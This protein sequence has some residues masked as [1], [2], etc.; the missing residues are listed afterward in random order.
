MKIGIVCPYNMFQ[1]AGGVQDVVV[2]LHRELKRKGHEVRVITPKPRNF[3]HEVP[4][5]YILLGRSAKVHTMATMVDIGFEAVSSEID[6][7]LE[8]E[9]FDVIHFHEP[10]IPL[11]SRQ[12]LTRSSAVN[13]GTF[14][15][16]SPETIMSKSFISSVGPYTKSILNYLDSLTAVSSAAS[17]YVVGMTDRLIEIV[18]NGID[19]TKFK[20]T[21][22]T[23]DQKNILYLGRLEKRKGIEYLIDAYR[24]VQNKHPE[25]ILKI[26][27]SGV[28]RKSLEKYVQQNSIS[29]VEFLGYVAEEDKPLLMED[30][31]VYCSPAPYGESFGI[32]LLEA[33]AVGTPVVAGNNVGYAS[34]MKDTGM[35]S[36]VNPTSTVDFA[37]RL[38]LMLFDEKVRKIWKE[39]AKDTVKQYKFSKIADAYEAVYEKALSIV[40]V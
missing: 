5:D 6:S 10:W 4:K 16:K 7:I 30:A 25:V 11:L 12:I 32:V 1:F 18:P 35:L 3:N 2:Q 13:I 9:K 28:K 22:Q 20:P 37:Q 36:L 19:L 17:E 21:G 33:M 39:W 26:A 40:H 15:A 38:E 27:G 34:V 31:T 8:N 14:H 23:S 29:G 24:L